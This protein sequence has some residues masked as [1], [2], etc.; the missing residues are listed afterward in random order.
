[1]QHIDLR[2]IA[3]S[4]NPIRK[5]WDEEQMN[6]LAES[7][8]AQGVIVPI[9]VRRAKDWIENCPG[10]RNREFPML[11]VDL[12]DYSERK[13]G[14]SD[15]ESADLCEWCAFVENDGEIDDDLDVA[16]YSGPPNGFKPYEIVYGHRRA[17]ATRRAGLESIPAIVDDTDDTQTLIQALIENVQR[18][19]MSPVEKAYGLRHLLNK[20][21]EIDN[22][23]NIKDVARAVGKPA[24]H[25]GAL[26]ALLNETEDTQ[27][28]IG[29]HVGGAKVA[30]NKTQSTGPSLIMSDIPLT[31]ITET[32]VRM[33]RAA[34]VQ[35]P[36]ERHVILKKAATEELTYRDT[37][38]VADAYVAAD[39]PEL[40]DAVLNTSGKLGDPQ[41]ILSIARQMVGV[42]SITERE[43][44]QRRAAF[45]EYDTAVKDF[46]DWAKLSQRMLG[47]ARDAARYGKFSPEGAR[48]AVQRIDTLINELNTV[49]KSLQEVGN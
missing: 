44:M 43:E 3:G 36:E 30:H 48:F 27:A 1:M 5:T 38:A 4:P 19:D 34:G 28:L 49:K 31:P 23:A 6:Q 15:T 9:K 17:E 32:H 26:L 29:K 40:K 12:A 24:H 25:I 47:A 7:I 39:T 33:A 20:L 46:L 16:D 11:C 18:E 45:E 42:Q 13:Y 2:L 14:W 41:R 35:T 22:Q 21:L 8:K 10:R 37:R